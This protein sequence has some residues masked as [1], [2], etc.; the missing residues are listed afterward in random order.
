MGLKTLTF[1]LLQQGKTFFFKYK[2][3]NGNENKEHSMRGNFQSKA[4]PT[5]DRQ[6]GKLILPTVSLHSKLCPSS[7]CFLK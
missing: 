1:A 3:K 2:N 4:T 6:Q 7:Y 5:N